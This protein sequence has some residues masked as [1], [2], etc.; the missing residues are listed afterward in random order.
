[1]PNHNDQTNSLHLSTHTSNFVLCPQK[2]F[3]DLQSIQSGN[4]NKPM[5]LK[6]KYKTEYDSTSSCHFNQAVSKFMG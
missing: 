4:K 6:I 2:H 5:F 3:V 1:M